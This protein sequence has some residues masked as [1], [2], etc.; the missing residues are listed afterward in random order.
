MPDPL[1]EPRGLLIY[2]AGGFGRETA[3]AVT[4]LPGRRLLGFVDDDP[5]RA[6]VLVDGVPIL[7]G[8]KA[9]EAAPDAQVV[10]CVGSPAVY[11]GR[12]RIVERLG[13]P[14]ARYATLLHPSAWV[15]PSSRI[16]PG[17]VVL[18]QTVLTASARVGAH[19]AIMPH[20]TVT[21]DDVV[22][23]Y[24]TVASGVR[25]GGGVRVGAGAYLGAG[26]LIRQGVEIGPGALVGMG[27][28]VLRDVPP[29]EVW[30]GSPARYLRPAP[31]RKET[32]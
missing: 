26:A 6:G 20:V 3:Q 32:P 12:R 10:V 30:V 16:G 13:L 27:A 11:D 2:G 29:G 24:A 7:G 19:V 5:G 15:S 9:V 17:S 8:A 25:L 14:P 22:E 23:D 18:A 31:H 1:P 21:H 28:V 4:A